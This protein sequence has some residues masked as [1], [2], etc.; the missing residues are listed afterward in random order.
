MVVVGTMMRIMG[1][2]MGMRR[3]QPLSPQHAPQRRVVAL[4]GEQDQSPLRIM[5]GDGDA[6]VGA[7]V[8]AMVARRGAVTVWG[9][10]ESE[11]APIASDHQHHD[12]S[13]S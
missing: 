4:V 3:R 1:M 2:R 12:S 13:T 5:C 10:G 8:H 9:D 11:R 7:G 6:M